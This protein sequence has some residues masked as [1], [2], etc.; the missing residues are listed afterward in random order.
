[1]PTVDPARR[2]GRQAEPAPGGLAEAARAW[3]ADLLEHGERAS[4]G[5]AADAPDRSGDQVQPREAAPVG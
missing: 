4:G 5:S 3:L 1:M 2:R